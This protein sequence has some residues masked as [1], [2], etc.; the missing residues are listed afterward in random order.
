MAFV[1]QVLAE[2]KPQ[3]D[4]LTSGAGDVPPRRR[5]AIAAKCDISTNQGRILIVR[6]VD[7][8]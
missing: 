5:N 6:I 8:V 7:Q 3:P 2:R 4:Q 1:P